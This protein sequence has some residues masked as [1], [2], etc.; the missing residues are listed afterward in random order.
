AKSRDEMLASLQE[1]GVSGARLESS[2]TARQRQQLIDKAKQLPP[3]GR[4][5]IHISA[6]IEKWENTAADV[7]VRPGGSLV[8]PTRP[9]FGI[10]GGQVYKP[11]AITYSKGKSAGW[12]LK[13]AGGP[14]SVA[15]K[16][17]IFVVR[18]NGTVVGRSSGE[19]WSGN[20]AHVALQPGDTVYVPDKV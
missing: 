2:A 19:W 8:V 7:E 6:P 12:Y 15:D 18:A 17:D 13:Q 16:K 1:Q 9:N 20:V 11:A 3:S 5:L 14:T 10:V 4:L